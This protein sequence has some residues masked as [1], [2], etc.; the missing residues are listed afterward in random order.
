MTSR[1]PRQVHAPAFAGTRPGVTRGCHCDRKGLASAIDKVTDKVANNVDFLDPESGEQFCDEYTPRR[2]AGYR[3]KV[4]QLPS[5][6]LQL[7]ARHKLVGTADGVVS[8]SI[9]RSVHA[10]RSGLADSVTLDIPEQHTRA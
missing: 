4:I 9:C 6:G 10:H 1:R 5:A 8:A 2:P 3:F 7:P